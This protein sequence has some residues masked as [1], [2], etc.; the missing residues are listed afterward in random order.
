VSGTY[1]LLLNPT[2]G[3]STGTATLTVYTFTDVTGSITPNGSSVP[4]T[5][6]S[7]GQNAGLTFSGTTGQIVSALATNVTWGGCLNFA[8]GIVNP[9]GSMLTNAGF[10][11]T[12]GSLTNQTLPTSGTYTV[13]LDPIG[14]NTGSATL[15]VTSP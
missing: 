3:T 7:P 13:L 6:A 15:T 4:I 11:S 14:V 9:D 12:N 10:C 8:L 1:T 5:I 2:G